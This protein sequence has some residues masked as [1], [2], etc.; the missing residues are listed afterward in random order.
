MH[1]PKLIA[2]MAI[3]ALAVVAIAQET[4]V[5][6]MGWANPGNTPDPASWY[7]LVTGKLDSDRY[8]LYPFERDGNLTIGY[9]IFGELINGIYN[10]SLW[11][12]NVDVFAPDAGPAPPPSVIPK[13]IW[14]QGWHINIT[15]YNTILAQRRVVWATA[16]FGDL[17]AFAAYGGPWIRA[18]SPYSRGFLYD[19]DPNSPTFGQ[20]IDTTPRYSGRKTNGTVA[21]PKDMPQFQILYDGPRRY[22]ARIAWDI[23]DYT[24]EGNVPLVRLIITIDFD[25]VKKAVIVIKEVKSLL[26]SKVATNMTVQLSNRGEIDLGSQAAGYLQFAHFFTQGQCDPLDTDSEGFTTVYNYDDWPVADKWGYVRPPSASLNTAC[27]RATSGSWYDV[28]QS[29][30]PTVNKV[31]F[32]AFWPELSDWSLFGWAQRGIS[33]NPHHPHY[34]DSSQTVPGTRP[35]YIA[36]WDFELYAA[37]LYRGS[38]TQYPVQFRG[39]AIYGIV[40]NHNLATTNY[41]QT[42]DSEVMY[43]LDEYFNP[44]D[45]VMAAEK[46]TARWVDFYTGSGSYAL[47]IPQPLLHPDTGLPTLGVTP[48]PADWFINDDFYGYGGFPERV[49]R[50]GTLLTRGSGYNL[51]TSD[52][53]YPSGVYIGGVFFGNASYQVIRFPTAGNYKV[54]FSTDYKC[55]GEYSWINATFIV[56]D[57]G[58]N[59]INRT[60]A[61]L[62]VCYKDI[63][64]GFNFTTYI[65]VNDT[66]FNLG[67]W[68]VSTPNDWTYEFYN[69]TDVI[70]RDPVIYLNYTLYEQDSPFLVS[71][72]YE[73]IVVGRDSAAVDSA[74]AA[75][76]SEA[77][78]SIKDIAV[79]WAGLDMQSGFGTRVPY[80]FREFRTPAI[81]PR[82]NYHY[83]H[84]AGDHRSALKDDWSHSVPI[85]SS[86]MIFVGGPFANLG[87][88]YFNEFAPI[89]FVRFTPMTPAD[90]AKAYRGTVVTPSGMFFWTGS[91]ELAFVMTGDWGGLN[92]SVAADRL[93]NGVERAVQGEGV[94]FVYKDL[95]G[96]VGLVI[97]GV[98]GED[99]WAIAQSF[100]QP[101]RI[102]YW[103][104]VEGDLVQVT[105]FTTLIQVLQQ[106]NEGTVG[107]KIRVTWEPLWGG[108]VHPVLEVLENLGTISEKPQH[109]DP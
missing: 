17:I 63:L 107:L 55:I 84:S 88:E 62:V 45:L 7:Y 94:V 51:Y 92:P 83:G 95:N 66:D 41:Y 37:D 85:A 50:G 14:F 47:Y 13:E 109:P 106:L 65:G 105:E 52:N 54:L 32:A 26:D 60:T 79:Q 100:F 96:T 40:D 25:K 80:V 104:P 73:W 101:T 49:L 48:V 12:K 35:Y 38:P 77:F 68:D 11:Y 102:T 58:G 56:Q 98:T 108:D 18:A 82:F 19:S 78:D 46:D 87:A 70:I 74:G 36:E 42:L 99:T 6:P 93:A 53:L 4:S 81:G 29:F 23:Y 44:F 8:T 20:I 28:L 86:N 91:G 61:R 71:G 5:E 43:I 22:I 10:I 34:I 89:V 21:P 59:I 76:V 2:I 72:A 39:V 97:Y 67:D 75:A 27:N 3:I 64:R 33:L 9:S 103:K 30:N 31:F 90:Y 1:N 69:V 57:S 24:G 16:Q 15:Y